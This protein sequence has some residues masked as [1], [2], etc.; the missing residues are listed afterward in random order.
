MDKRY[1]FKSAIEKMSKMEIKRHESITQ[2]Q[3][4]PQR[5]PLR[6]LTNQRKQILIDAGVIT[7][8]TNGHS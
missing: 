4:I 7:E 3:N 8:N 6:N 2:R 5:Y 1:S